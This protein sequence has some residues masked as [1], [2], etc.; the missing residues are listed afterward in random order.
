MTQGLFENFRGHKMNTGKGAAGDRQ[1][2]LTAAFLGYR[3][4]LEC[5][6]SRILRRTDANVQDIVQETFLHCYE[7]AG[8]QDIQHPKSFMARTATNLALNLTQ[9]ADVRLVDHVEDIEAL[10]VYSVTGLSENPIEDSYAARER[11]L[12]FCHAADTLP[13]KC[14]QAFLLKKVYGLSQ[15]EI[16]CKMGISESTVEKHVAKGLVLCIEYMKQVVKPG[17]SRREALSNCARSRHEKASQRS[18]RV[19]D[20][21][22]RGT[23]DR[24][25]RS[26]TLWTGVADTRGVAVGITR[27]SGGLR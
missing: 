19:P 23:V 2:K 26:R 27:A 12:D 8:T 3:S 20:H 7:S 21:G 17:H 22:S 14:R 16:S 13:A 6:V 11:F 5:I 24:A 9:R 18:A 10:D 15:S 25:H 1:R 4:V